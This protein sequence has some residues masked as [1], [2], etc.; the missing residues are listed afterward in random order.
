MSWPQVK[1]GTVAQVNPRL[2]SGAD[3]SQD[4]SFVGMAAVS[5]G[6]TLLHEEKRR[7]ADTKK[8]FTYFSCDDVLLAKITPCFEN[9]KCLKA[10]Q[11][12]HQIGYGSTEFHVLRPISGMLDS[13]YLFY[14]VWNER[15][16][17]YGEKAMS[18]AA[19]RVNLFRTLIPK[20]M[21]I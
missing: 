13:Q 8:G 14:M 9:G 10:G 2:P 4:V 3:E 19:E 20:L 5:E 6:G 21:Y 17:F 12:S 15:F 11:I 18:G 7:L 1:L 16:R